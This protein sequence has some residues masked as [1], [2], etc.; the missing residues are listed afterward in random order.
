[1]QKIS[2]CITILR[3]TKQL[4]KG[5]TV[6]TFT[7]HPSSWW[8]D[9]LRHRP[10]HTTHLDPQSCSAMWPVAHVGL[11][12]LLTCTHLQD[13]HLQCPPDKD[14]IFQPTIYFVSCDLYHANVLTPS[15]RP[16]SPLYV[17]PHQPHHP[18]NFVNIAA[19]SF[20]ATTIMITTDLTAMIR[21][22]C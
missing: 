6:H 7:T 13:I 20:A 16:L 10:T 19:S 11:W 18:A 8:S 5:T 17:H 2:F 22:A 9:K 3:R 4:R 15:E 21:R 1:M 12:H 14:P